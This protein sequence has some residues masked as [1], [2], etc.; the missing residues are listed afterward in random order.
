MAN[1]SNSGPWSHLV[2]NNSDPSSI[3]YIHPSDSHTFQLV[4]FKFNGSDYASWKRSMLLSLSTKN[5]LLFIDGSAIK[6]VGNAD[7][8]KV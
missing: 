2:T 8:L 4:S 5:K 6:T 7:E 1:S 3:Y